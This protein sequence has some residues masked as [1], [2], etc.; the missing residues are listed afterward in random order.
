[1]TTQAL[2]PLPLGCSSIAEIRRTDAI[3]VDKTD[4][5][6][7]FAC[8]YNF[9][10]RPAHFGHTLLIDM[11]DSLYT[12]GVRDFKGLKIENLWHEKIYTVLRLDF[13]TLRGF[14]SVDEFQS[15]FEHCVAGAME[16]AGITL[17]PD[18]EYFHGNLIWRFASTIGRLP[19]DEIVLLIDFYDGPLLYCRDNQDLFAEVR[20]RIL[21]FFDIVKKESACMHA[22]FITGTEP[23][24]TTIFSGFNIAYDNSADLTYGSLMGFT[25]EELRLHFGDHIRRAAGILGIGFDECIVELKKRCAPYNFERQDPYVKKYYPPVFDP[26]AVLQFL[27]DPERDF[28]SPADSED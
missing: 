1:M 4:L 3:F 18:E 13:S 5:L 12:Y 23:V 8:Y 15:Q 14:D 27:D 28:A 24:P 19:V 6:A 7:D 9:L 11:L 10:G 22:I 20:P 26:T 21:N 17:V 25:E 16:K 2:R